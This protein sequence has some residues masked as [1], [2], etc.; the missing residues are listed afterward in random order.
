MFLVDTRLHA[1]TTTTGEL[2][3]RTSR[4]CLPYLAGDVS[5]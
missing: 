2:D 5:G 4:T 1:S 3:Y